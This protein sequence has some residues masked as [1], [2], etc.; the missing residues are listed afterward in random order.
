M[1]FFNGSK[2]RICVDTHQD[3]YNKI[4][5]IQPNPEATREYYDVDFLLKRGLFSRKMS[6]SVKK[7]A[8]QKGVCFCR[9]ISAKQIL[10]SAGLLVRSVYVGRS[11]ILI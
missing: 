11:R 9:F 4:D 10:P 8:S 7:K 5:E 3:P 6:F 1:L 2:K